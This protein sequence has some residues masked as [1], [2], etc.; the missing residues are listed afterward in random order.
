LMNY[1]DELKC[2]KFSIS[3]QNNPSI[4]MYEDRLNYKMQ[5]NIYLKNNNLKGI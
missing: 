1:F 4:I 2:A 5:Y 3:L